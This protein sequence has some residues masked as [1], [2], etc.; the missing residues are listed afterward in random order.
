MKK[1]FRV[2]ISTILALCGIG[3]FALSFS[4]LTPTINWILLIPTVL[5]AMALLFIA[6]QV[7]TGASWRDIMDFLTDTIWR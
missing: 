6:W 7:A 1:L 4:L 2:I 5:A 3:I